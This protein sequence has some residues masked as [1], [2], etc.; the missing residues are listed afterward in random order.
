M[1]YTFDF[2]ML[3]KFL[4]VIGSGL[5]VTL[6]VAFAAILVGAVVGFFL[7][8]IRNYGPLAL[9]AI[10]TT[11][12]EFLRGVPVLI[13]LF[14]VFFCFPVI[15][16]IE[17]SPFFAA[18]FALM[19][20][21]AAIC[22]ESFRSAFATI[23]KEQWDASVALGIPGRVMM[24]YVILPQSL[25][26]A[27]PTLLSNAVSVFKESAI[28]S[29]VGMVDMMFVGRNVSSATGHPIEVLTLIAVIYFIIAFPLT[30]AVSVVEARILHRLKL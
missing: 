20:Y 23:E 14:W 17:T 5:L 12:V 10:A 8:Y 3:W 25:L 24:L 27:A 29:A 15:F 28:V 19:M 16:G 2:S 6:Q 7:A 30:Q 9:A 18:F 4:P 22:S 26:R 1:T 11:V 13:Q 21:M